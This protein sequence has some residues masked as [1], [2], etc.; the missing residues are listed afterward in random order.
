MIEMSPAFD[1]LAERR[2]KLRVALERLS[3]R[4]NLA[5]SLLCHFVGGRQITMHRWLSLRLYQW[6]LIRVRAN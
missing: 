4:V 6:S 5:A 3:D 1:G 2:G